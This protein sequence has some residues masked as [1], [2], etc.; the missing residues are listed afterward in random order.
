MKSFEEKSNKICQRCFSKFI[1]AS[2]VLSGNYLVCWMLVLFSIL[3][4]FIDFIIDWWPDWYAAF[5]RISLLL[6]P[7]ILIACVISFATLL[8]FRKIRFKDYKKQIVLFVIA[9]VF[10]VCSFLF[11]LLVIGIGFGPN[12][13]DF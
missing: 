12:W 11:S 13:E 2:I 3:F 5:Y 6:N 7:C 8:G 4:E 10:L 1:I 9:V